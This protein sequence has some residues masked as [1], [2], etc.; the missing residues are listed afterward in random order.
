MKRYYIIITFALLASLLPH[1]LRAQ[2]TFGVMGGYG[3]GSEAIYP[4][5]EGRSIYGLPTGGVTWRTYSAERFLGCVGVDLLYMQRGFSYSPYASSALEGEDLYY[6]TRK[7]NTLMLPIVWQPCLYLAEHR[8]RVFFE[9]AVTFNYDLSSTYDNDYQRQKDSAADDA[10]GYGGEYEYMTARDNRLGYGLMGGGGLAYLTGKLE[11]NVR[12]RYYYGLSDIL[13]NRTK[14]YNNNTDGT[15]NPFILTSIRSPLMNMNINFGVN[16]H[17]GPE[18]FD[19]WNVKRIKVKMQRDF[20]YSGVEVN[21]TK[22]SSNSSN[23]SG[24]GGQQNRER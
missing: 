20:N 21:S 10:E 14:Y 3:S 19:S 6:Y 9:A 1:T 17:F 23:N 2:H 12:L 13:R 22:R 18:G 4:I 11:F 16:Y 15:E 7:I 5:V 8:I 24:K